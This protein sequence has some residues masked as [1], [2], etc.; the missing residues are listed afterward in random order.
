MRRTRT[1]LEKCER[2]HKTVTS[3]AL[4]FVAVEVVKIK[5]DGIDQG[6]AAAGL[7]KQVQSL[8]CVYSRFT[9]LCILSRGSSFRNIET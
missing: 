1:L 3:S 6:C 8:G 5:T 9:F 4:G 7:V 2:P